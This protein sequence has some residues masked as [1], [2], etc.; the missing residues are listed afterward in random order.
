M[1]KRTCLLVLVILTIFVMGLFSKTSVLIDFNLLKA[2]G[3]GIDPTQSLAEDDPK[4]KDFTDHDK[5]NR[6]EHMPTLLDYSSIAGSNFTEEDKKAMSVSLSPYNWEVDLN[7]SAAHVKNKAY[8][9]CIEWHTRYVPILDDEAGK[10]EE[11]AEKPEGYTILGVRVHFPTAGFNSWALVRPPFEI[12]AYENILTDYQ[13]NALPEEEKVKKE[14]RGTKYEEGFGVVKNVGV[15]KSIALKVYGNQFKN[16]LAILLSDDNLITTE[17]QMP[18][19]LDFDGWREIVWNNPNYIA[20]ASNRELYVIPLYPR[21]TPFMKLE[22]FRVYRQGDQLGGDFITY[23]KDVKITYD[24]AIL[25]RENVP[26]DHEDAWRILEDKT[27]NAKDRELRGVGHA[28]ILRF[29]EKKKMHKEA[30]SE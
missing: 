21:N 29:L 20:E 2:N 15:L 30:S 24:E 28:Q 22:G 12:P 25:E 5:V 8:S 1:R 17:Y 23:I 26:I 27:K 7:S 18:T 10:R 3:N 4:M 16:S 6:R 13:G 9:Y 19:Y 11:G 14:N